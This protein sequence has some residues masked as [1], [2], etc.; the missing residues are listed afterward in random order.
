MISNFRKYI[1]WNIT[2]FIDGALQDK[3]F[4]V[5]KNKTYYMVI[6]CQFS[7]EEYTIIR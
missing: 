1:N 7:G 4:P 5:P 2:F 6:A 3:A